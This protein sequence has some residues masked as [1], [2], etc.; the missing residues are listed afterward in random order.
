MVILGQD[1]Y[2]GPNQAMGLSFSVPNEIRI[3]PSLRNIYKEL[4]NDTE[5]KFLKPTHGNLEKWATAGV[6]L[7]NCALTVREKSPLSH[8][9]YWKPFTDNIIRYILL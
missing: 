3:P 2:H 1:C 4:E 6:L 9:K 5:V 7:L 8:I